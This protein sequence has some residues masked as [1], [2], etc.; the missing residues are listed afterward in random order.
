M[1]VAGSWG[2]FRKQHREVP[3]CTRALGFGLTQE[4]CVVVPSQGGRIGGSG[5]AG[6]QQEAEAHSG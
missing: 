3:F 4:T 5:G 2:G 1:M 6:S